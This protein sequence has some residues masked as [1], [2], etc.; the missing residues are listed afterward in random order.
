MKSKTRLLLVVL[1]LAL[2]FTFAL[3]A[4]EGKEATP[5]SVEVVKNPDKSVYL[6]D[7]YLDVTGGILKVTYSNGKAK[8]TPMTADM[9]L[10]DKL[11]VGEKVITV[12]Y[13][14]GETKLTT[15]WSVKVYTKFVTELVL[16]S[17]PA[18]LSYVEG[19]RFESAGI[20]VKAVYRDGSKEDVTAN[21]S[22]SKTTLSVDD[23]FVVVSYGERA[24]KVEVTVVAKTLTSLTVK[25]APEKTVY[26]AGEKFD[27]TGL[28]LTAEYNDGTSFDATSQFSFE[29]R[30][31]TLEDTFVVVTYKDYADVTANVPVQV[32]SAL[33]INGQIDTQA[34]AAVESAKEIYNK[35][36]GGDEKTYKTFDQVKAEYANFAFYVKV[37]DMDFAPQTFTVGGTEYDNQALVTL[38]V[39]NN[40]FVRDLVWY[41]D[42]NA[43]ALYASAII[44]L[45][46]AGDGAV[47]INDTDYQINVSALSGS[48]T[49]SNVAMSGE[50]TV[51]Q[52]EGEYDVVL[53]NGSDM[54]KIAYDGAAATDLII[55]KKV[56]VKGDETSVTYGLTTPESDLTLGYYPK[57]GATA[58]DNE[59]GD[60]ELTYSVYV[61]GKGLVELKF[62]VDIDIAQETG[63][64]QA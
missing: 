24:V 21:V 26:V 29:D 40:V 34:V 4:C 23:E 57:W 64:E 35:F 6:V 1:L 39:G 41:W 7:D 54:L 52:N 38:S 45:F 11:T 61:F 48:L 44:V 33:T 55:T 31:L 30:A 19:Q 42:S 47:K 16:V 3:A 13:T 18:K 37:A 62:N 60:Y 51:A 22:Y 43:K 5:V 59:S 9:V 2:T 56:I 63:A 14:E 27:A 10:S 17:K 46:E 53:K 15:T 49:V 50:S 8:E 58:E 25:Q 36:T 12:T 20:S 28:V 32:N